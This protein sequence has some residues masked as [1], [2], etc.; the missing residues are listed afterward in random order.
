MCTWLA[1]LANSCV[2]EILQWSQNI[3]ILTRRMLQQKNWSFLARI[4]KRCLSTLLLYFTEDYGNLH[5]SVMLESWICALLPHAE[6]ADSVIQEQLFQVSQ[7][8]C[9]W[10]WKLL[11]ASHNRALTKYLHQ[12]LTF[13]LCLSAAINTSHSRVTVELLAIWGTE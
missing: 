1:L 11:C 4:T 3:P 10:H 7:I 2:V 8:V 9:K 13:P 5:T 12:G 6:L